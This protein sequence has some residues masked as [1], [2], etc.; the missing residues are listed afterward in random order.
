MAISIGAT[1]FDGNYLDVIYSVFDTENEVAAQGLAVVETG[2]KKK[3]ALRKLSTTAN[4]FG[5]YAPGAPVADTA[6][7]S[8]AERYLEPLPMQ[9]FIKFLPEDFND[10]W[11]DLQPDGDFT[12]A[13]LNSKV[14][15]AIMALQQNAM[16][17][18]ISDLFFQGN[19][20]LGA[21]LALNKFNGVITRAVA[22]ATVPKIVAV[23]AITSANV[24]AIVKD[25]W[26]NIPD[27][28]V[29]NPDYVMLMNMTD[30]RLLQV[31]NLELKDAFEGILDVEAL[32]VFLG[33]K[34]IPLVSMPKDYIL[35]AVANVNSATSN[36]FMGVDQ[37]EKSEK[38]IIEKEANGSKYYFIRVD[39]KADA[40]YRESTELL[41]YKPA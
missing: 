26:V 28:F 2:I 7:V 31:A 5:D 30:Y 24:A 39:V 18:Q 35:G 17:N 19:T 15:S 9:M 37:D 22:D 27:K 13:T 40:N 14:L 41:L 32:N 12:N 25:F 16:S 33:K 1:T 4:P 23:G 36:L 6:T 21:G 20:S 29:N 8:Y 34:I 38:P 3:K 10:L 11:E